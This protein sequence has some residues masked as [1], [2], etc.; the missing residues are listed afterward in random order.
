MAMTKHKMCSNHH[1][2]NYDIKMSFELIK[3]ILILFIKHASTTHKLT[4]IVSNFEYMKHKKVNENIK[5]FRKTYIWKEIQ[6]L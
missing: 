2:S 5:K 3:K 1:S 4:S 6:Q